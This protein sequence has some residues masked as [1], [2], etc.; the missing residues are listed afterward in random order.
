MPIALGGERHRAR[1]GVGLGFH[2]YGAVPLGKPFGIDRGK[3]AEQ[4]KPLVAGKGHDG[5]EGFVHCRS[6][7]LYE[8]DSLGIALSCVFEDQRGEAAEI[9]RLGEAGEFDDAARVA[10]EFLQHG[11]RN[12][13]A[14]MHAVMGEQ[15]F[16]QEGMAEAGT[17]AEALRLAQPEIMRSVSRGVIHKNT[18]SRKISRLA[19]RV[20]ALGA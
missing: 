15:R 14:R 5:V 3:A 17:A 11:I 7:C 16:L 20:K 6:A 1:Q 13:G 8:S 19:G 18:A 2:Q 10:L 4:A 12:A 9:T